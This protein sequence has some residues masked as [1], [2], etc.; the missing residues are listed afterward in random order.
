MKP[1]KPNTLNQNSKWLGFK[2]IAEQKMKMSVRTDVVEKTF[3]TLLFWME[4]VQSIYNI[5]YV[6]ILGLYFMFHNYS[7]QMFQ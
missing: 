3:V 2:L 4:N 6:R 7:F 1:L 5:S